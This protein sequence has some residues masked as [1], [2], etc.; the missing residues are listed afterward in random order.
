MN[1]AAEDAYA[2]GAAEKSIELVEHADTAA[3][4]SGES[5][6]GD[7]KLG[8]RAPAE[9]EAGVED[10]IDDVGDPEKAHG[11]GGVAG[12]AENGVVEKEQHDGATAAECDAR[13]AGAD[14]DDLRGGPHE[15]KQIRCVEDA[16]NANQGGDCETNGDGLDPCD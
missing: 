15:A 5:S 7:A 12:A 8:E 1:L 9:N 13:V 2:L 3:G 14:G 6:S 11:Y 4:E 10:E 16:W